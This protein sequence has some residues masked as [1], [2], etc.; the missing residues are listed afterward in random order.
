MNVPGSNYVFDDP[1]PGSGVKVLVVANVH[2]LPHQPTLGMFVAEQVES[3]RRRA[4]IGRVDVVVVDG[5]TDRRNYARGIRDVRRAVRRLRPDVVH[6]HH[7]LAGAVALLGRPGV[8]LVVTYHGSD[9][10]FSRWQ[11]AVSRIVARAAARNLCV[12][13]SGIQHVGAPAELLPCGIDLKVMRPLDRSA[14]KRAWDVP[15][16][17]TTLLF[18]GQRWRP[19]KGYPRFE[20]VRDEL[21]ARGMTIAELRLED[22]ER[23]R[24]PELFAAADVL[25]MTSLSEGAPVS[26]MEALACGLPAVA[27]PVGDVAAMLAGEP[28][29]RVV[30]F[31]TSRFADAVME[32]PKPGDRNASALAERY[33]LAAVAARLAELYHDL[34]R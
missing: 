10:A 30:E 29:A 34:A 14:A 13:R 6:A 24:V 31:N 26:L 4:D 2:P 33:D 22:V 9:L 3:L 32:L 19:V 21:V 27:P 7:G 28:A 17:A 16:D 11:R 1:R 12:S 18:P 23:E 15:E 8:P 20:A 25:V 5:I